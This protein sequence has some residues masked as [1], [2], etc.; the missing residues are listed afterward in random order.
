MASADG[1][2]YIVFNGE[3]YNYVELRAELKVLGYAFQ[4]E[5]DTEVL[6]AAYSQWGR[7][8][9]ERLIGMFAFAIL[10][11]EAR[12]LLLARDFFGIKP[13]YYT[14]Q[15]GTFAFAS[16]VKALLEL[17]GTRRRL[18]AQQVYDYLR[19]GLSD[20]SPDTFLADIRQLPA[21]HCL[22][23]ALDDLATITPTCYWQIELGEPIRLSFESAAEQLRALFLENVRLHLRSDV[24]VGACLSGGID[25]S[26]IVMAM[27]HLQ[28]RELELHTFSHISEEQATNEEAWID[29][30]GEAAGAI[31][32]KVRPNASELA[33][34]LDQMIHTQDY[35]FGSTSIYAQRRVFELAGRAGIKVMLDG[36]GADEI[37][38]GYR[39]YLPTRLLS[40]A[41]SG[42]ELEAARFLRNIL[43]LPGLNRRAFMTQVGGLLLPQRLRRSAL[44]LAGTPEAPAWL[45]VAWFTERGVAPVM[46]WQRYAKDTLRDHLLGT[47]VESSVPALLRYEDRNSMAYSIESR[48]PFLTPA[49]VGFALSLP[50]E[51]IIALDGTTKAI[52]RRAMR[53]IVPDVI[54]NRKD[55]IG[56]ATPERSWLTTLRPWVDRI[57]DSDSARR[58]PM[59]NE[60]A[61]QAEW[62]AILAGRKPFDFRAWRWVN[63]IRWAELFE[64][65]FAD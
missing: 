26:A 8:A 62:Q 42:K 51:Y 19:F 32:H 34:D 24:P 58:M 46:P 10:D 23:L 5:S 20:H 43:C 37:L 48:V 49:L 53:G 29:V 33:R 57:I 2:Y 28:G 30:V 35:P 6:L 65:P 4:S 41:R 55:K 9:L 61:L 3:I 27:R 64:V 25:S 12:T 16:E 14:C 15:D 47:L 17:P 63:L 59:L 50:D 40:L 1:R 22:E 60:R 56:F 21:A 7:R 38:G 11:V 31:M 18:D 44:K 54:L 36:Q 45:N 39:Y 52:F 13:L